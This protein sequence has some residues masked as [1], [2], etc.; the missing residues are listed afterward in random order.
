MTDSLPNHGMFGLEPGDTVSQTGD[1]QAQKSANRQSNV[2]SLG[3]GH[4]VRCP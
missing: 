3:Y 1:F 2:I 4:P